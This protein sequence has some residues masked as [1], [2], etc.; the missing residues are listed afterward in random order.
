MNAQFRLY[1]SIRAVYGKML[2]LVKMIRIAQTL[3]EEGA[4]E[5][6]CHG[7]TFA[8]VEAAVRWRSERNMPSRPMTYD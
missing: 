6:N 1:E 5:N 3:T 8:H 4:V 7:V 2:W